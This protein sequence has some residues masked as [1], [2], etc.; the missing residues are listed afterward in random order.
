M[1]SRLKAHVPPGID[2]PAI[3]AGSAGLKHKRS[4]RKWAT[5][6][7]VFFTAVL[8]TL[9]TMPASQS[10]PSGL[11]RSRTDAIPDRATDKPASI[12]VVEVRRETFTSTLTVSGSLVAREEVVI[13]AELDIAAIR[14]I[15][16]DEGDQVTKGQVLARLTSDNA[17]AALA[18]NTA[19]IERSD[20]LIAQAESAI[21]EAETGLLL[22]GKTHD[23]ARM[24]VKSGTASLD[25][26]EQRQAAAEMA[27]ARLD[28]AR[29]A[30]SLAWAER[31][32]AQAQR[33]DLMIRL[34]RS[35]VRAPASGVVMQRLA[36]IG[37]LVTGDSGPL[38][39]LI[40]D[41][42]IELDALVPMSDLARLESDFPA[43]VT[44]AGEVLPVA[45]KVRLVSIRVD[46]AS[47]MGNVRI[48]LESTGIKPI[49]SFARAKIHL[50]RPDSLVLPL[51]AVLSG[52]E[53]LYVQVVRNGIVESRPVVLGDRT[54]NAVRI[55]SG[56][57]EG[58]HV[59]LTAGAWVRAGERVAASM[60]TQ[61]VAS[62][63]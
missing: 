59:I 21:R 7:A 61:V 39:R 44:V 60:A 54:A 38:F 49:G 29:H 34:N 45:G 25:I 55:E 10:T 28:A 46:V 20:A 22:A 33:R 50:R 53:G 40:K 36:Q 32:L 58:E 31:S 6:V 9:W 18:V 3:P 11:D 57:A 17:H 48:T 37:L 16:V 63:E 12:T 4:T 23:R 27:R 62:K 14:E 47:R 15:L 13:G 8:A 51:S 1:S 19:Q 2:H 52:P 30:R 26:L 24:L 42:A 41:G 5:G 35:E 43:E 56:I